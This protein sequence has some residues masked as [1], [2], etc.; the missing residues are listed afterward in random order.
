MINLDHYYI[1][2]L[3]NA[4]TKRRCMKAELIIKYSTAWKTKDVINIKRILNEAGY[5]FKYYVCSPYSY[6]EKEDVWWDNELSTLNVSRRIR[7]VLVNENILTYEALTNLSSL[8]LLRMPHFSYK[9]L[10]EVEEQ[11]ATIGKKLKE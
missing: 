7:N 8:D 1:L 4:D 2:C 9:C 6:E 11:L 10:E 5:K 3:L